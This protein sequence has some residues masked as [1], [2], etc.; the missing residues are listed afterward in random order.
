MPG[1]AFRRTYNPAM[2]RLTPLTCPHCS[3]LINWHTPSEG[4]QPP[5]PGDYTMCWQCGNFSLFAEDGGGGPFLRFATAEEQAV[6]DKDPF[7]ARVAEDRRLG[8]DPRHAAR[9]IRRRTQAERP[10]T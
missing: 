5:T 1:A 3:T 7:A 9:R 8:G 4:D 2:D 6:I 10:V